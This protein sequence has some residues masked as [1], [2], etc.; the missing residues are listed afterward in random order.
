MEW[1][2]G[3]FGLVGGFFV[4]G[5][6]AWAVLS[7]LKRRHNAEGATPV[8]S[9]PFELEWHPKYLC[10]PAC[11]APHHIVDQNR[12]IP[13]VWWCGVHREYELCPGCSMVEGE[14]RGAYGKYGSGCAHLQLETG[15]CLLAGRAT[16]WE[17][18]ME[19]T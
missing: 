3:L 12:V 7:A 4:G 14:G 11:Y 1:I 8:A 13:G 10:T 18:I 2:S 19:G 15:T 16:T 9:G 17:E 5:A 6:I